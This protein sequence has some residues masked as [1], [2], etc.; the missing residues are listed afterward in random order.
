[1]ATAEATANIAQ[2]METF[3]R[4]V[5]P[6]YGRYPG[7]AGA[8]RGLVC[9]GRA[10][11]ALPRLLSRLGLRPAGPLSRTD[12]QSRAGASRHADPRA[13]HLVH[14]GAGALGQDALGAELWR[15]G[16]LLQLGHRGQRSG[17]QAGAAARA[18]GPL[19]DHHLRRRLPRPHAGG[20]GGHGPAEVSRRARPADGRLCLCTLR[21]S[22]CRG[23]T[24][25]RRDG[26]DH[27]RAGAGRR[28]HQPSARGLSGRLAANC[29]RAGPAAGVRRSA[30][31]LRPHRAV[32]RLSALRRDARHHDAGQGLV[33]RDRRRGAADHGRD[34]SQPAA[35]HARGHVRRQ[36]DRCPGGH[37][38]DR[39]D[40]ERRPAG[41]HP[42]F[43]RS[44]PPAADRAGSRV[45]ADQGSAR[46]GRDDRRRAV[47]R[48]Q[49]GRARAAWTGSCSSTARTAP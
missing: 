31:R 3:D 30:N 19:Q 38:R 17:D 20:H 15:A 13:Q 47:D 37:R 6:N 40:R 23:A 14:R 4:Y 18:E 22:G 11:Q 32:V 1:M 8:R 25:R 27:D 26:R 9:L 39:D 43:G 2:I 42:A 46:A 24:G 45:R 34:R 16:L 36:S 41:Q 5:V 49:G 29:R 10:G 48:R 12:R 28:G 21:R 35:R 44:V 7:G 33:R